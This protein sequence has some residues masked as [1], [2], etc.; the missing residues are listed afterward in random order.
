[1]EVFKHLMIGEAFGP[2]DVN[3]VMILA[4]GDVGIRVLMEPCLR[5]LDGREIP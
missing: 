5:I 4:S 3:A 1:M 2:T